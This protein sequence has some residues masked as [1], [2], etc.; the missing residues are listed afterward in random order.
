MKFLGG[1]P[2]A[3]VAIF[4]QMFHDKSHIFEVADARFWVPEPKALWIGP[5]KS[6]RALNQLG[7][8]HSRRRELV[9]FVGRSSHAE[10]YKQCPQRARAAL[11]ALISDTLF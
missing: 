3:A 1:E 11:R 6:G 5:H 2:R 9:Q 10:T 7:R 8:R 4:P